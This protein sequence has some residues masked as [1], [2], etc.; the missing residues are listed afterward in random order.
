MAV[1]G[2]GDEQDPRVMVQT[3]KSN[4]V[5]HIISLVLFCNQIQMLCSYTFFLSPHGCYL[6]TQNIIRSTH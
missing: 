6:R 1:G 5:T 4:Y 3:V 2:R